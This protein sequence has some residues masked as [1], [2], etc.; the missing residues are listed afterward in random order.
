[1]VSIP[2]W[3]PR[4]PGK[5]ILRNVVAE[6]VEQEERVKVGG[7]AEAER[8]AEVNACALDRRFALQAV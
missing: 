5:V 2:R 1:M 4:E 7:I 6:I 8:A 3:V